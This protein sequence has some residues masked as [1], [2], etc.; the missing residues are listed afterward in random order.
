MA[1]IVELLVDGGEASA[2]PPVGP[3]LGPLGINV[4]EVVKKINEMTAA[5]KGMKVPVKVIVDPTTKSFQIEVG[6]PPTSALIKKELGLEKGPSDM[7]QMKQL[8]LSMEQVKKIAEIKKN[9][10]LANDLKAAMLEVIGTALS[11]GISVEGKDP[12]EIQKLIKE[13]KL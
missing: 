11:M 2:G 8:S 10:M 7:S 4:G 5:M 6:T 1:E 3:A 9:N 12:R 13:G